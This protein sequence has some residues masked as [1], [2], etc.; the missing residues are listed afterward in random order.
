MV[1]DTCKICNRKFNDSD[2]K[3]YGEHAVCLS[4]F[5]A[6]AKKKYEERKEADV[7]QHLEAFPLDFNYDVKKAPAEQFMS[8][9][10]WKQTHPT[11]KITREYWAEYIYAKRA[12]NQ[13]NHIEEQ[14]EDESPIDRTLPLK[15][16]QTQQNIKK[17]LELTSAQKWH[18]GYCNR[19]ALFAM[20]NEGV[21]NPVSVWKSG[22][23]T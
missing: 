7:K 3:K 19:C 12:F 1:S 23:V 18:L 22:I 14:P 17:G 9:E 16:Q 8:W 5:A 2:C 6:Q 15:C 4:C 21:W 10:E 13:E 20:K 11:E